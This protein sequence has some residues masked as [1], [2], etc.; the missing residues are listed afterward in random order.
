MTTDLSYT[1]DSMF[2]TFYPNTKAGE[3]A[4]NT[5]ANE[6]GGNARVFNIHA[7]ST[8]YQLKKAG[9]IVGKQKASKQ[10][11]DEILAE[12]GDLI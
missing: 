10:T 4:W 12:L 3:L 7:A 2:T 5:M 11:L 8:I 1:T 6:M 9:Y